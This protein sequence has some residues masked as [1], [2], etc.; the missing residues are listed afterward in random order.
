MAAVLLA[1]G[2]AA[3][4]VST[5][6]RVSPSDLRVQGVAVGAGGGRTAVLLEGYD[7]RPNPDAFSLTARLGTAT[8][9]GSPQTL[10]RT[11]VISQVAVGAD[12]T[13]VAVW[14]E[15]VRGGTRSLKTAIARPN[16]RFG[17]VRVL[18]GPGPV[19][20]TVDAVAVTAQGRAVVSWNDGAIR[21]AIAPPGG[22]FG[23]PQTLAAGDGLPALAAAPDGTVIASWTDTP[24]A[25][26]PPPAP[27]PTDRT[28][29]VLAATLAPG[30]S[31]FGAA[32][33]LDA[34][35]MW[36]AGPGADAGPGGAAV[37]WR[38]A[39]TQR[40]LVS[41]L[42]GGV[43]TSPVTMPPMPL[44]SGIGVTD[45]PALGFPADGSIVALWQ[46]ATTKGAESS[47]LT[48]SV[49]RT[50][51]RPKGRGFSAER[52]LSATGRLAGAPAAGALTDRTV[53]AWG[54]GATTTA[55]RLRVAVR[56]RGG[57]TVRT[58]ITTSGIDTGSLSLAAGARHVPMVWI[59]RKDVRRPGG[60]AYLAT[61]R[62]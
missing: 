4:S 20:V 28:A 60:E 46:V 55:D 35:Q 54:E 6:K 26:E 56:F 59:Q 22:R 15:D 21:V 8:S 45:R 13:A 44:I 3:A 36:F 37:F 25:P 33:Q 2:P 52:T 40:R 48:S 31:R 27:A 24:P 7:S 16:A 29:E 30:A 50:S 47:T 43:F 10:A 49:V 17:S 1:A 34:L 11:S 23:T 62:P 53:A 14:T 42:P 51:T 58:P 57:W 61:Y 18:A 38:A 5:P 39:G 32:T 9:L 19:R 41:V 12:G